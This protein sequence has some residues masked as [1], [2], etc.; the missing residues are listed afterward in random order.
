ME[1][2]GRR[3]DERDAG[4][5]SPTP[6]A[7]LDPIHEYSHAGGAASITG[8]DFVP[9][10]FWPAAH[11]DSYCFCGLQLRPDLRA[12][13]RRGRPSRPPELPHRPRGEQRR[14]S[15]VRAV[16][17]AGS[18]STTRTTRRAGARS[19]SSTTR[20]AAIARPRAVIGASPLAGHPPLAVNFDATGSSDPDGDTLTYVW[21]FGDGSP[22]VETAHRHDH[23]HLHGQRDS[24]PPI[25]RAKDTAGVLSD[26]VA[27]VVNVG[28]T[29]PVPASC[30]RS[31]RR[32][33][34]W[35]SR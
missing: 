3:A 24:S 5:C 21:T 7:M 28:N 8:G 4:K 30:A 18:A 27:V 10:G 9:T 15:R 1:L 19:A 11:D 2:P 35:G 34:A 23:P 14:A 31:R 6:P 26:P 17:R 25:L 16:R 33:S 22:E 29:P 13:R 12:Q 20:A 32:C